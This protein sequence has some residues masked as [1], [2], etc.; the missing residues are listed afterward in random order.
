MDSMTLL[1]RFMA[2]PHKPE[3][4]QA[5]A[6]IATLLVTSGLAVLTWYYVRVT[7]N[8]VKARKA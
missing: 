7:A 3:W 6:G 2:S 1:D 4:L 5:I 8:Q